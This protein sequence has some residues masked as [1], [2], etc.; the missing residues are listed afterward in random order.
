MAAGVGSGTLERY[1]QRD[2]LDGYRFADYAGDAR[3]DG[4]DL[5]IETILGSDDP[6]TVLVIGPASTAA[7]ALERQPGIARNARFV[8]MHGALRR[9]YRG[10]PDPVPEYNVFIDV[11][12]FRAVLAADWEVTLTPLDTCG[13][14]ILRDDR[15]QRFLEAPGD[16]AEA[17]R[18]NYRAWAKTFDAENLAERRS[19]TLYD[20]VAVYLAF[21]TR[22]LVMEDIRIKIADDGLMTEE[23]DGRPVSTALA[24]QDFDGYLDFL[25]GRLGVPA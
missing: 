9:G 12:A 16:L 19:T 11:D 18:A 24:W 21:T 13:E 5:F 14:V 23:P 8:G 25:L 17:V 15:Y 2:W 22:R 6:V 3:S 20:T 1:P 10:S 4:V 7:A